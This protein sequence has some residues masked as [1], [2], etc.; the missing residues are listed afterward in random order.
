VGT[1]VKGNPEQPVEAL[2]RLVRVLNPDDKNGTQ[3]ETICE[4]DGSFCSAHQGTCGNVR[5]LNPKSFTR[6]IACKSCTQA[7]GGLVLSLRARRRKVPDSPEIDEALR[8]TYRQPREYDP[9]GSIYPRLTLNQLAVRF[10]RTRGYLRRRAEELNLIHRQLKRHPKW[11]DKEEQIVERYAHLSP[12][13]IHQKLLKEGFERTVTAIRDRIY[14]LQFRQ[15]SPYYSQER[16]AKHLGVTAT[17]IGRWAREG[18][19]RG[20]NMQTDNPSDP[21]RVHRNEVRRFIQRNPRA[22]DLCK[23]DQYW[24]LDIVFEGKIAETAEAVLRKTAKKSKRSPPSPSEQLEMFTYHEAG[25]AVMAHLQHGGIKPIT[26][27][28]PH[29]AAKRLM[30]HPQSDWSKP[31]E[32]R[33]QIEREILVLFAGQ[34]AQNLFTGRRSGRGADYPQ[35]KTLAAHVAPEEKERKAYLDWLWLRAQNLLNESSS[36]AAV[37]TLAEA[38]RAEPEVRGLRTIPARNVKAIIEGLLTE[39]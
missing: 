39:H 1:N 37:Q 9:Y 26:V 16:L 27:G 10:K 33:A 2:L 23:V 28:T 29:G 18:T 25:H 4:C 15:D 19:L 32:R 36:R 17:L 38:L 34:I 14:I 5:L 30:A 20:Q 7:H 12:S 21:W 22:I 3:F 24:F 31:S 13:V 35:A 8:R 11:T 6:A